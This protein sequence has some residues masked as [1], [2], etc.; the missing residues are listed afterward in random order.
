MGPSRATRPRRNDLL[1]NGFYA[2]TPA[3]ELKNDDLFL[4]VL[5]RMD[6]VTAK[7]LEGVTDHH[8]RELTAR[9]SSPSASKSSWP[10][11][12]KENGKY[13]AYVRDFFGGNEFYLFVYQ[14][15]GDVRLVGA[16]PQSI[17]KFGGDTDNWMWPR[18]TG[19]FSM[20]RVYADKAG[21]P[22]KGYDAANVPFAPQ[23]VPAGEPQPG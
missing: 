14:R 12:A 21:Q 2:P 16:P 3:Q 18:H 4:D 15:Y 17:G 9:R 19:D 22:T 10:K 1:T 6:D 8:A 20:F 13:V 7:V 23:E 5:V 11:Y